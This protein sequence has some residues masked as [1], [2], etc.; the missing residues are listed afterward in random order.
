MSRG[1]WNG[2]TMTARGN[3]GWPK[4]PGTNPV[5]RGP[6]WPEVK[7]RSNVPPELADARVSYQG[8]RAR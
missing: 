5:S 6:T 1:D 8:L 2:A 7:N 4:N 3:S